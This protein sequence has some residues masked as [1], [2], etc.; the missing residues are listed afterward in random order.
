MESEKSG[1]KES[2]NK[3]ERSNGSRGTARDRLRGRED[4][5]LGSV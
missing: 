4:N 5:T 3:T 1:G 2:W